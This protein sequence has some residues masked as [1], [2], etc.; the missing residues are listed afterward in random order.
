VTS[1]VRAS[2]AAGQSNGATIT[3]PRKTPVAIGGMFYPLTN[4]DNGRIE[5]VVT[6]PA[7][8]NAWAIAVASLSDHTVK[9]AVGAVCLGYVFKRP[10]TSS[11]LMV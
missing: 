1:F 8:S 4:P 6:F 7:E 2:V 9:Y 3:C 10:R 5:M 11:N